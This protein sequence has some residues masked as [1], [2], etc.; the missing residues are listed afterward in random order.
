M[1]MNLR[2]LRAFIAGA[3]TSSFSL[4]AERIGISQPGFSLLIRQLE[5]ELGLKLFDRTTRHVELTPEGREFA[6]RIQRVLDD[7]D[8]ACADLDDLRRMR[9]GK[10]RIAIL[11]S[12]ASTILPGLAL[13]LSAMAPEFEVGIIERPAE[14][15]QD[16]VRTG[17]VDFGIGV[18]LAPS[19]GLSFTSLVHDR[20]VCLCRED[21]PLA[22][23]PYP[24][25]AAICARPFIGFAPGTSIDQ[26]VRA[27]SALMGAAPARRSEIN[28]IHTAVA[29]ARAG[30]GVTLIPE[31]ALGGLDLSGLRLRALEH[32]AALREIGLVLL[33]RRNRSP[34]TL[35]VLDL[36]QRSSAGVAHEV[37]LAFR[38]LE[39][40]RLPKGGPVELSGARVSES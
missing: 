26:Q 14:L 5:T 16:S 4:A 2:Q 18:E 32:P 8:M 19:T 20:L 30:L 10:V 28:A 29:M 23:D 34:A 40:I 17:E 7:L 21:D 1:N 9:R 13:R 22:R 11:P 38:D 33:R 24:D 12:A 31:L 6:K 25:W 27:L 39:T 15:I 36:F 37:L 3:E 35:T